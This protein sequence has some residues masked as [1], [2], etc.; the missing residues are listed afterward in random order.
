MVT[1][2]NVIAVRLLD[3]ELRMVKWW[4]KGAAIG[5]SS[6]VRDRAERKENLND[7]QITG[8][9]CEAAVSKLLFGSLQPYCISRWQANQHRRS[10]D[11]GADIP[12]TNIDVKGS[13]MRYSSDP[14]SYNLLVR[15]RER[16]PGAI[17]FH[18]LRDN[19][20]PLVHIVGWISEAHMTTTPV[21]PD[22]DLHQSLIG[23]Y[24]TPPEDLHPIPP[25]RWWQLPQLHQERTA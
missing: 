25:I 15:P 24:L 12:G 20:K 6:Q 16:H 21:P 17:Y 19:N 22:T 7:D 8:Q 1:A 23:S 14:L 11:R 18:C 10:G 13:M 5:G 9:M 2:E 4:A 3:D